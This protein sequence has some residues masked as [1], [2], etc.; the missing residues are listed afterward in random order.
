MDGKSYVLNNQWVL[1]SPKLESVRVSS[2]RSAKTSNFNQIVSKTLFKTIY[3]NN[4]NSVF[5]N[6]KKLKFLFK[7]NVFF[8]EKLPNYKVINTVIS[9]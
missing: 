9:F 2:K 3:Y 4:L 8:D 7:T 6:L 5:F 1:K